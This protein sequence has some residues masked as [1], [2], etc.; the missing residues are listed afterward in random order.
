MTTSIEASDEPRILEIGGGL[1]I[2]EGSE[3]PELMNQLGSGPD[4]LPIDGDK[5]YRRLAAL[6]AERARAR[7]GATLPAGH[8]AVG[9]AENVAK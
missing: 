7:A 6:D 5:V 8:V 9:F 2:T 1:R 4:H 3:V